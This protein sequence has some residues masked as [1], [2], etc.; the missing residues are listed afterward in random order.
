[1]GNYLGIPVLILAAALQV[2]FIPQLRIFGGEPDLTL[3]IVLSWAIN[4]NLDESVAW[5]F[6]GGISRD[7]LTAAPTGASVIGM[8]ILVFI[9]ERLR[10]QVFGFGLVTLVGLV[11]FGT[12][13]QKVI[14][15]GVIALVGYQV[16]PVE[17]FTYVVLPTV[18]Y[19]LVFIGPVYWF[20]RRVLHPNTRTRGIS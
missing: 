18:A 14:Y 16:R 8:L 3:L 9:I 11:I 5:A 10:Q 19:N 4:A 20:V 12:L 1:M 15:M 2:S 6:F 17:M 13:L 7:L